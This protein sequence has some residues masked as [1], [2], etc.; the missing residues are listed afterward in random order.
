MYRPWHINI[1][2]K[3]K[4]FAESFVLK[5]F[6]HCTCIYNNYLHCINLCVCRAL[7]A[8]TSVKNKRYYFG[9]LKIHTS[10]INLSMLT[11]SKLSPD[12]QALKRDM[13]LPLVRFEDAKVDLGIEIELFFLFSERKGNLLIIF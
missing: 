5:N 6:L 10:R 8:A 1:I 9:L 7:A 11:A 3:Y 2:L 12:L 4:N 13:S